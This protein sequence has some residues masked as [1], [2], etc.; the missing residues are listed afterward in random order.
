M[1]DEAVEELCRRLDNLPLAI[2]LAAARAVVLSPPQL[3][4]RLSQRLDLLRGGRDAEVRQQT[5]RA[6]IAWSHDLLGEHEQRLL[7][8]LAIF[9]GGCT[10]A[11]AEEVAG[12][13]LDTLQALV[14]KSLLRR[15]GERF[16]MLETIREFAR[17]RLEASG[18]ANDLARA[19]ATSARARELVRAALRSRR[20]ARPGA[21][22][23]ARASA[24]R[25]RELPRG[26]ELA[27]R[28]RS[29]GR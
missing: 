5:L 10:L 16:W 11:A 19:H 20:G 1:A 17:E 22:G 26:A 12:A 8:R 6:T 29:R 14:E 27:A 4:E 15:T 13:D 21:R 9:V 7:A 2:E 28:E 24:F 18:E 23:L 3:L 25:A